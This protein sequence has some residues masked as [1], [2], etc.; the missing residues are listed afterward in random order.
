MYIN[1]N[2]LL[3]LQAEKKLSLVRLREIAFERMLPNQQQSNDNAVEEE[4]Q[5]ALE[6]AQQVLENVTIHPLLT[7]R[8]LLDVLDQ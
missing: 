6:L 3:P 8:E 4:Q 1:L 2:L 7:T 5:R